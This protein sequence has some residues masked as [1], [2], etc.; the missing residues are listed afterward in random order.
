MLP[1]EI[2]QIQCPD[3]F[4][5]NSNSFCVLLFYV[6]YKLGGPHELSLTSLVLMNQFMT[7]SLSYS[8]APILSLFFNPQNNVHC[9]ISH[10]FYC[11][12]NFYSLVGLCNSTLSYSFFY[13]FI[14]FGLTLP[15]ASCFS[16]SHLY[17]Q[18]RTL[19]SYLYI[20]LNPFH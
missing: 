20:L 9:L 2:S 12:S 7:S 11:T 10:V 19:F 6:P 16:C 18:F 15:C 3:F 5:K 13:T 8:Y 1:T 14:L 17:P 4:L